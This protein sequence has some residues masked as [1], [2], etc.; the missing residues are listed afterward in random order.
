MITLKFKTSFKC[1]GCVNSV[2]T[3]LDAD[4]TIK[5]WDVDLESPDRILTLTCKE[6]ITDQILSIVEKA[7]HTA[8]AI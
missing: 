3:Q 5:E 4:Q 2:R 8:S 6:D 1:N 7:G